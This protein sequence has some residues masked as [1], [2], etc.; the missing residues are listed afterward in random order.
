MHMK[1]L[2]LIIIGVFYAWTPVLADKPADRGAQFTNVIIYDDF[3]GAPPLSEGTIKCPGGEL[4]WLNPVTP[5]CAATGRIHI[6]KGT[7]ASCVESPDDSR[8][9]GIAAITVNANLDADYAGPVWGTWMIVPYIGCDPM[10][11]VDPELFSDSRV[12]WKGIWH[13]WRSKYCL[14]NECW[15]IGDLDLVGKGYGGEI[16]GIHFKGNEMLTTFTPFP[17]AWE[18][19]P[20]ALGLPGGPEGIITA[21]IKE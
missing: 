12:Y 19:L 10:V 21:T 15:W 14:D 1:I 11:P 20:P 9:T 2:L 13:G 6:R 7:I 5:F 16:D 3:V 18:F 4:V 17:V 8:L